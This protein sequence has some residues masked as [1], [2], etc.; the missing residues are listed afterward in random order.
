MGTTSAVQARLHTRLA[1]RRRYLI[2]GGV[3]GLIALGASL[4]WVAIGATALFAGLLSELR[5]HDAEVEPATG[6]G[7][8]VVSHLRSISAW[9]LV[10]VGADLAV[11][12]G[13]ATTPPGLRHAAVSV[14]FI[15][16]IPLATAAALVLIGRR[17]EN[18]GSGDSAVDRA[19]DRELV[20]HANA[21]AIA[22]LTLEAFVGLHRLVPH[23]LG[24][25]G[26]WGGAAT[27][28]LLWQIA[29]LGTSVLAV[30][31]TGWLWWSLTRPKS[32][33]GAIDPAGA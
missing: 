13:R 4:G 33:D 12:A 3:V 7:R 17:H 10:G 6:A 26:S 15:L 11:L 27:G 24:G 5:W 28:P 30:A 9:V 1:R 32:V 21:A 8:G 14:G 25:S 23:N 2:G 22:L 20:Q 16:S 29:Y 19:I 31:T 18:W